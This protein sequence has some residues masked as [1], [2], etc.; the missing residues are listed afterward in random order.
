MGKGTPKGEG[1]ENGVLP[2]GEGQSSKRVD[3]V[4]SLTLSDIKAPISSGRKEFCKL[5]LCYRLNSFN[6]K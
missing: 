1:Q 4:K 5:T 6:S 2:G 3:K